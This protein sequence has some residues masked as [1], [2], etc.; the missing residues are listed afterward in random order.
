[1]KIKKTGIDKGLVFDFLRTS[2]PECMVQKLANLGLSIH[3]QKNLIL[4]KAVLML[5]QPHNASGILNRQS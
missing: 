4:K 2:Y 5:L 1:M 3:G